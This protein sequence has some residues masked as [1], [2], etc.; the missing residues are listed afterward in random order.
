MFNKPNI[1][2]PE[3]NQF[4]NEQDLLDLNDTMIDDQLYHQPVIKPF[5]NTKFKNP[6]TWNPLD[7]KELEHYIAR[8]ELLLTQTK[9]RD[10]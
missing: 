1:Q 7:P 9:P 10:G 6:S 5:Q 2:K 4:I 8:N 3:K